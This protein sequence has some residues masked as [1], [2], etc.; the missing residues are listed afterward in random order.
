MLVFHYYPIYGLLIAFKDFWPSK[1]I[2]GSPWVGLH[3]FE[4]L[5]TTPLFFRALR[6]TVVINAYR[7]VFGFPAPIILALLLNELRR[8][9]FKRTVQT[10]SYMP[11]F[12][13][14]VVISGILFRFLS[15]DDG[16]VNE[17]LVLLGGEKV[18]FLSRASYF[19]TILVSSQ[20]WK[21]VGYSSIIYLAAI[22][23]IPDELY[24][25]AV[26]D[27][28]GRWR[29][30]LHITLPSLRS[31]I[32]I[33][34]LFTLARAMRGNFEQVLLLYNPTVYE[35]GDILETYLY[36][37]G[38]MEGDFSLA[39]ALGLFQSLIGF[40]LMVTVNR[41]VRLAGEEGVY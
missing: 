35:T 33:V 10:I 24:M 41:L 3:N 1:G 26:V 38:L 9:G 28:A 30:T 7:L 5:F 12:V 13:S 34:L 39:T 29:Q 22:A 32:A 6:N 37:T 14:W 27:G 8:P 25:A 17:I 20:I 16:Q 18:P 36:R 2:L 31:V 40:I 21:E 15:S 23:A 19:R 4:R 11:H